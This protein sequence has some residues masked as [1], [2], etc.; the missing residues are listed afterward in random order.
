MEGCIPERWLQQF[1]PLL[2]EGNIYDIS[3]FEVAVSKNTYK[4]VDHYIMA[5]F[6][7]ATKVIEV[8]PQP[9]EFPIYAYHAV[10]YSVLAQRINKPVLLS[11]IQSN[12]LY[13]TYLH[14]HLTP[15]YYLLHIIFIN[16]FCCPDFI[17][18]IIAIGDTVTVN[19]RNGPR[20]KRNIHI[21][22]GRC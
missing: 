4:C 17:G 12:P 19:T 22:D 13:H 8:I 21:T 5:K 9:Q 6:T 20:L 14:F 18:K 3:Y 7:K 2:Q 16:L 11:G 1:K 15:I 10:P